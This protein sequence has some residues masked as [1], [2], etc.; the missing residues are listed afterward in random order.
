MPKQAGRN[1]FLKIGG[2]TIAA[3]RSTQVSWAGSTIDTTDQNSSGIAEFLDGILA[4]DTLQITVSG[5][6]EDGVIK[7]L[8][9]KSNQAAKFIADLEV[10]YP[11]GDSISGAF[12]LTAYSDNSPHDNAVDFNATFVRNGAHLWTDHA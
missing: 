8:S 9:L 4:T 7:K 6:E 10:L 3:L 2:V 1:T 12:V 5:L 11:T